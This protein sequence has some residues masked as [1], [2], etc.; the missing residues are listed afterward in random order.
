MFKRHLYIFSNMKVIF[1]L[2]LTLFFSSTFYDCKKSSNNTQPRVTPVKV[3]LGDA[4]ANYGEVNV[5]VTGVEF[6]MTDGT[7]IDL[8]VHPKVI[9]L[10]NFV[11]GKDSLIA[12]DTI[13]SGRLSQI[14]LILGSNNSVKIGDAVYPLSTPSAKQSGL[15]L[16]VDTTLVAGVLYNLVLDFDAGQS[17]V[18][19]GNGTFQLKPVIR[20]VSTATTGS[21][22]GAISTANALPALISASG[23]AGTFSTVTDDQGKFLIRGVPSGNYTVTITPRPGFQESTI[24]N[25]SVTTG[26]QTNI[27][28]V[29]L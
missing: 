4:P 21:I 3:Y 26:N 6:N 1:F 5:E 12:S 13:Q 7:N 28:T 22:S 18:T 16:K 11:N 10:L 29:N 24:N 8:N 27:G 15:K 25:V 20:V 14:R 19:T 2:I 23:S 17:I 9:N